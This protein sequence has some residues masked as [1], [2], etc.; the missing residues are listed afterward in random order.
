MFKT[1]D[2]VIHPSWV[3]CK[4]KDVEK[5]LSDNKNDFLY[6]LKPYNIKDSGDFKILITTKQAK[7]SGIRYPIKEKN[8]P[9]IF[10]V[11]KGNP[12][13][14]SIDGNE[15]YSL[16]KEKLSNGNLRNSAEVLR[17][18]KTKDKLQNSYKDRELLESARKKL[19]EEIAYVKGESRTEV[20][21]LI[22]NALN[23]RY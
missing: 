2:I 18:L 17:D 4:V 15:S 19:V 16:M 8:I 5:A 20:N 13:N 21:K 10:D 22:D 6:V 11:L 7:Q 1:G 3:V 23:R 12:S 14:L 9:S